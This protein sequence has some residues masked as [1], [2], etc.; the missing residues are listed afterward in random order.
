MHINIVTNCVSRRHKQDGQMESCSWDIIWN[1]AL[2]IF[3]W[4]K[5]FNNLAG[6]L[7]CWDT[8]S[9]ISQIHLEKFSSHHMFLDA[10]NITEPVSMLWGQSYSQGIVVTNQEAN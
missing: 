7:D 5:D 1:K 6:Q 4:K 10:Q 3:I 9:E 8:K 2:H